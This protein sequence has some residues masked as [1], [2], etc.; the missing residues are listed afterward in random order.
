MP[1]NTKLKECILSAFTD[2]ITDKNSLSGIKA[3]F[4]F[5]NDTDL[6]ILASNKKVTVDWTFLKWQSSSK[7]L[8]PLPAPEKAS[9]NLWPAPA[10]K[11]EEALASFEGFPHERYRAICTF[12]AVAQQNNHLLI[13]IGIVCFT[14]RIALNSQLNYRGLQNKYPKKK[15]GKFR[16]QYILPGYLINDRLMKNI[17][18]AQL[19]DKNN[20]E[21]FQIKSDLNYYRAGFDQKLQYI[22]RIIYFYYFIPI[23]SILEKLILSY[24]WDLVSHFFSM[25]TNLVTLPLVIEKISTLQPIINMSFVLNVML[26]A[27]INYLPIFVV[28]KYTTVLDTSLYDVCLKFCNNRKNSTIS[29]SNQINTVFA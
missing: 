28:N 29:D 5:D 7:K 6:V 23:I 2:D 12:I 18:K 26:V 14:I 19:N 16:Y 8:F 13:I 17:V 4:G 20:L 25:F 22:N 21:P 27:L 10:Q 3:C 11:L 15:F 24:I 1:G 9:H